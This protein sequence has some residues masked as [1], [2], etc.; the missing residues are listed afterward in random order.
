MEKIPKISSIL[1]GN[2]C[3]ICINI[4]HETPMNKFTKRNALAR[5]MLFFGT[6][7]VTS[8]KTNI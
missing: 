4:P 7:A 2:C 8:F 6:S 3:E 5:Q 1:R